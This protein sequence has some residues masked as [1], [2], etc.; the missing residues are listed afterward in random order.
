LLALPLSDIDNLGSFGKYVASKLLEEHNN[1]PNGRDVRGSPLY[2]YSGRVHGEPV[3]N[4]S[5]APSGGAAEGR[6]P[7]AGRLEEVK[8]FLS[9]H[10][11]IDL[12]LIPCV[13]LVTVLI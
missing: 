8:K 4:V 2:Q 1:K 7:T 10:S 6:R 12:E 9:T 13:A 5:P 11:G 3:G